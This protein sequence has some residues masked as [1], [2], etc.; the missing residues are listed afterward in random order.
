MN[1]IRIEG[2]RELFE[3]LYQIKD[4][5]YASGCLF[6]EKANCWSAG[7]YATDAVIEEIR[8][9]GGKVIMIMNNEQMDDH[10]SQFYGR[11][12]DD[13]NGEG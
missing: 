8:S 2:D 12:K 10:L 13:T 5:T 7:A 11:T 4:L 9:L 3:K 1:L 6:D